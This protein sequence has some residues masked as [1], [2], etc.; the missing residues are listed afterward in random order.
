MTISCILYSCVR[1]LYRSPYTCL[2]PQWSP[3]SLEWL[4]LM[5]CTNRCLAVDASRPMPTHQVELSAVLATHA[6]VKPFALPRW[7]APKSSEP[8]EP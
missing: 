7:R 4:G 2:Q 1:F 5:A 3:M 6:N 8:R